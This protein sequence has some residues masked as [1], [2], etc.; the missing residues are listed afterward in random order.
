MSRTSAAGSPGGSHAP[1]SGS[2]RTPAVRGP[3]P[4]ARRATPAARR[5]TR[6]E[7]RVPVVRRVLADDL[8][9]G[10]VV[11]L[12]TVVAA[13]L[14]AVWPR[15][16]QVVSDDITR[17]R[18]AATTP[19]TRDISSSNQTPYYGASRGTALSAVPDEWE[20]TFGLLDGGLRQAHDALPEPL[21]AGVLDPRMR[22]SARE[23]TTVEISERSDVAMIKL[24]ETQDP[25]LAEHVTLTEGRW[26]TIDDA[27]VALAEGPVERTPQPVGIALSAAAAERLAWDVGQTRQAFGR[28]DFVL[29]GTYTADDPDEDYWYHTPSA[30][31][32][33]IVDSLDFG[34]ILTAAAYRGPGIDPFLERLDVW[35]DVDPSPYTSDQLSDISAQLRGFTAAPL[36][37]GVDQPDGTLKLSSEL[38]GT[39]DTIERDISATTTVVALLAAGPVAGLGLL[40]LAAVRVIASRRRPA[41]ALARARGASG[42]Q[43]RGLLAVEG[44]LLGIVG[45]GL[46]LLGAV[47]L[48]PTAFAP[49][50]LVGPLVAA[51]APAVMLAASAPPAGLR[52]VRQ[53]SAARSTSRLR[54]VWEVLVVAVAATAT[55]L[56]LRRGAE[57]TGSGADPLLAA[58]PALLAVATAV[59]V[60]R[61]APLLLAPVVRLA[62]SRRGALSFL[63]AASATRD[64]R[65]QLAPLVGLVVAVTVAVLST[66]LLT[67]VRTGLE[68][69]TWDAIGADLRSTGPIVDEETLAL[70]REVPGV[71]AAT[72]ATEVTP[73]ALS[74]GDDRL[75]AR[76]LLVDPADLALVQQDVP[77]WTV[78]D[79]AAPTDGGPLPAVVSSRFAVE[80]GATVT[81]DGQVVVLDVVDQRPEVPGVSTT[82][83]WVLLDRSSLAD[84]TG[85]T[86]LPRTLLVRLDPMV[87]DADR[88]AV[89]ARVGEITGPSAVEVQADAVGLRLDDPTL[90]GLQGALLVGTLVALVVGASTIVLGEVMATGRRER[91]VAVLKILG[92]P[93]RGPRVVTTWEIASWAVPSLVAG[94]ALGL[95]LPVLVARTVDLRAFTGGATAPPL[96][97][98]PA[99]LLGVLGVF[100]VVVGVCCLV[101]A[102]LGRRVSSAAT[103]RSVQE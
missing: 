6:G 28:G 11:L 46:G 31:Q 76:V 37:Y 75:Q 45:G 101:S 93:A 12:V 18:L 54:G 2:P 13:L 61:I 17:H 84:L 74:T 103:L 24:R 72:T 78:P 62:R 87:E 35:F 26:P 56:V 63:G 52:G 94:L 90:A 7:R 58:T 71:A 66:V 77:G 98:D 69:Q 30:A 41:L 67:T 20:T 1:G 16:V 36:S 44:L 14:L 8:R 88:A 10:T 22:T 25:Y 100:V 21:R 33:A 51:L 65:G 55:V 96:V 102:A 15:A 64:R 85:T 47:L 97:Y 99:A 50:V 42:L 53:D 57:D 86:Y 32:P 27:P 70:V 29:L 23:D 80:G 19:I 68:T 91:L 95:A 89:V 38:P 79:L 73:A 9:A 82:S 3:A 5:A 43:V 83:G 48:V 49:A 60:A 39:L 59:A 34:I 4:A 92:M 81:V 40:L